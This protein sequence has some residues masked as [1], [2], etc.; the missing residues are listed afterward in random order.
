MGRSGRGGPVAMGVLV[1][2]S[3][4]CGGLVGKGVPVPFAQ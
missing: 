4:L 3:P 2:W 1:Y